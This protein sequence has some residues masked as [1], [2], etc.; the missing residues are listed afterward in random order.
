MNF[1]IPTLDDIA[2]AKTRPRAVGP[3]SW[4]DADR[5]ARMAVV[6][7]AIPHDVDLADEADVIRALFA[8]RFSAAD[9]TDVLDEAINHAQEARQ[10]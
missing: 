1:R 9:F 7:A 8:A 6:A 4:G 2:P 5:W 10:Q 3:V